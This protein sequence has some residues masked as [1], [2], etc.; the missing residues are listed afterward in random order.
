MSSSDTTSPPALPPSGPPRRG[1]DAAWKGVLAGVQWQIAGVALGL[2]GVLLACLFG[3]ALRGT[4]RA[5]D[6]L[7][8]FMLLVALASVIV[9]WLSTLIGMMHCFAAPA[10]G[11]LRI[12]AVAAVAASIWGFTM[13]VDNSF[14]LFGR[15]GNGYTEAYVPGRIASAGIFALLGR[16]RNDR[17]GHQ[18]GD[19][20][21]D[22]RS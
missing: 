9:G 15:F 10:E 1:D 3:V 7:A 5:S 21:A 20:T 4:Y 11:S 19:G 17:G 6:E 16:S 14:A 18:S 2:A 8:S 22:S 12:Y 13:F